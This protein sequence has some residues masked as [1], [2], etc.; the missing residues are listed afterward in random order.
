METLWEEE[1]AL[2]NMEKQG[3]HGEGGECAH[4]IYAQFGNTENFQKLEK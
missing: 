1:W 3:G 2:E 4:V